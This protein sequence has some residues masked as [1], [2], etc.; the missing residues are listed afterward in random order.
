MILKRIIFI[1]GLMVFLHSLSYTQ[2]RIQSRN[3]KQKREVE[4]TNPFLSKLWYGGNLNLGFNSGVGF[5]LFNIGL[6]PMVGYKITPSFSIGP[7]LVLDYTYFGYRFNAFDKGR[8]NLFSGG[9]GPFARVKFTDFIFLHGEFMAESR[10]FPLFVGNDYIKI[11]D[12][13]PSLSLGIGY[14]T[15][16]GEMM[17]L[18]NFLASSSPYIIN[19]FE[20]RF[21][22][23]FGF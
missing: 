3:P 11:R 19:P 16:G 12:Y 15:G 7:R 23:T 18:Y 2:Q 8:L 17:I 1:L 22:F 4:N 9:I 21:G 10:Q 6:A 14:N 20:F 13:Q 5:S